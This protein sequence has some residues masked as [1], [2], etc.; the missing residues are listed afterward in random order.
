MKLFFGLLFGFE[1]PCVNVTH[2]KLLK[3]THH[4]DHESNIFN[5]TDMN[6]LTSQSQRDKEV[7]SSFPSFN[8]YLKKRADE[9]MKAVEEYNKKVEKN[10]KKFENINPKSKD[11]KLLNSIITLEWSKNWVYDMI[12]YNTNFGTYTYKDI[13]LMRDFAD[14]HTENTFFYIGYFPSDMVLRQGPFYIG[15]FEL[16]PTKR[17]FQTHLIIQNPNYMVEN[18]YDEKKSI[19]NLCK[20]FK[21]KET[22]PN[23]Y[24]CKKDS[25]LIEE[26]LES[27]LL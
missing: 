6:E 13:F 21:D 27:V 24:H 7:I 12:S 9:K 8:E 3:R 25:Q 23:E 11:L 19:H 10:K 5:I 18:D 17:E 15:A 26:V 14:E 16:V 22:R 4:H 20:Q 1:H 2:S